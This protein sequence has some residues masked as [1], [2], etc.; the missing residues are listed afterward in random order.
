[1][2]I[3][4]NNQVG[5]TTDP[6]DGRSTHHASDLAKGFEVP[7]IHVNADDP[8]ACVQ[9]VRFAMEYRRGSATTS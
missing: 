4:V 2:H 6:R 8:A 3:I 5:F 1:M 7:V 9:A